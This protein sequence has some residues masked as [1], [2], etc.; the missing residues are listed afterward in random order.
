L[1][2]KDYF[3]GFKKFLEEYHWIIGLA[4]G[5]RALLH[6]LLVGSGAS[7]TVA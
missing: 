4:A 3:A 7:G 5:R 2:I 6:W 1:F